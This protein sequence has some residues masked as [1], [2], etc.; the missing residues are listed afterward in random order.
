MKK[1]Y[2]EFSFAWLF[3]ILVGAFILFIALYASGKI[4]N[5]GQETQLAQTGKEIGILLNP[6]ETGFETG[7]TNSITMPIET[8]IHNLCNNDAG[9]FGKQGIR[10]SQKSFGEWA[11]TDM[12]IN[13][14]NK[15]IFSENT[16]EG[17]KFYLFSKPFEFP[18]KVT[19]FIYMSGSKEY[20][21][22][23]EPPETIKTELDSLG[24]ENINTECSDS[25]KE[26]SINVCFSGERCEIRVDYN[27]NKVM[28]ANKIME[29]QEDALM[30]AAIF[31]D[32]EI[33][34][35]QLQRVIKRM[36]TLAILYK[37]KSRIISREGC[38]QNIE[39]NKLVSSASGYK[40]SANLYSLKRTVEEIEQQNRFSSCRLW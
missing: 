35:C 30:Y 5:T 31:S 40:N 38:S 27:G 32:P 10:V 3:A 34:E 24:Q 9:N 8:R 33:Y 26:N 17:K 18:Y 22:F 1:G 20:Y 39:L 16:T 28:K 25:Q 23:V 12:Y 21:C 14:E 7:K 6:L 36:K 11:E 19:D 15:Y 37:E 13:F 4:L 29:F 2:L